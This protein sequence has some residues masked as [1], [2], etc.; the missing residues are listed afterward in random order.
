[1]QDFLPD[2][3]L[4][5]PLWQ[6][7]PRIAFQT[8]FE[9]TIAYPEARTEVAVGWTPSY[10]YIGFWSCYLELNLFESEDS[11]QQ[12]WGLWDRDVVEVF[13]NPFPERIRRYWEF[14]VAPNNQWIDLAIDQEKTPSLNAEWHSGFDHSTAVDPE[15][16]IWCCEMRLPVAAFGL[17][18]IQS[19]MEWRVNFY[20]C[21]G[22]GDDSVRRFLA[23][24][25]TYNASFHTPDSFGRL[26][27][28][29]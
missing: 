6:R 21:D 8:S 11:T 27:F 13:I 4:T 1:L 22:P 25:P 3:D 10:V 5:K 2:G 14:E 9:P 7:I 19:G 28:V 24:S 16:K 15:K 26:V 18:S 29:E 17:E 23:W 20:R 12:R